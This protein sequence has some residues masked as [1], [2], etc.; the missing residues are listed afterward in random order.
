M[1][2][3]FRLL[4]CEGPIDIGPDAR[5]HTSCRRLTGDIRAFVVLPV[6]NERSSGETTQEQPTGV[7][8]EKA[9]ETS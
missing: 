4:V 9:V 2:Y 5:L 6:D 3:L 1:V 8:W 7:D